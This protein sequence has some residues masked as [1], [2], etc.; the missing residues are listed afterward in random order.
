MAADKPS[1]KVLETV[2]G[3]YIVSSKGRTQK[4]KKQ[5]LSCFAVV[6]LLLVVV[7]GILSICL[8]LLFLVFYFVFGMVLLGIKPMFL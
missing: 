4:N 3:H 7:G 6:L 8:I 1:V 5:R 2:E